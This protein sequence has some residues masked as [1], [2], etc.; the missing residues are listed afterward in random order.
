MTKAS[1]HS[2]DVIFDLN[3]RERES[4]Y[5]AACDLPLAKERRPRGRLPMFK[6]PS[7]WPYGSRRLDYLVVKVSPKTMPGRPSAR[8]S[9]PSLTDLIDKDNPR[10]PDPEEIP[11]C[12]DEANR[13][14]R[15]IHLPE[16]ADGQVTRVDFS[17]EWLRKPQDVPIILAGLDARPMISMGGQ[18]AVPAK[19]GTTVYRGFGQ[20]YFNATAYDKHAQYRDDHPT[21]TVKDVEDI[22]PSGMLR[23]EVRS[24]AAGCRKIAEWFDLSDGRLTSANLMDCFIPHCLLTRYLGMWGAGIGFEVGDLDNVLGRIADVFPGPRTAL[25]YMVFQMICEGWSEDRIERYL[26]RIN[27]GD[28]IS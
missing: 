3:E 21:L 1:I 25:L 14:L 22:V 17:C 16:L 19:V 13:L 28:P 26:R 15:S 7:K 5:R 10:L 12:F 4:A 8:L 2:L 27:S 6:G 20:D 11:I 23:F 18:P 9:I 24:G